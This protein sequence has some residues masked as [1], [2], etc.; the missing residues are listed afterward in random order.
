MDVA[1]AVRMVRAMSDAVSAQADYLGRL[2][3][4]A[5]DGDH[6]AG[7]SRGLQTAAANLETSPPVSPGEALRRTGTTLMDDMGGAAG[8]LFGTIFTVA[9]KRAGNSEKLDTKL[10]A[11]MLA[12][13]LAAV[14]VRGK[15]QPGDK[16]M[17]DALAPAMSAMQDA[18]QRGLSLEIAFDTAVAAAE[19][20]A[21]TTADM[22]PRHGRARFV[23]ERGKGHPDA[24]AVSLAIM[25]G[26]IA[27][28]LGGRDEPGA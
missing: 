19:Q 10:W 11:Q 6:G 3:S 2:D 28:S 25:L 16:T 15:A 17:V 18:A 9:A 12:D 20:G 21:A 23:G 14:Q 1:G 4:V 26:A 7:I 24:G 27:E 13:A 22:L 8:L 5:G